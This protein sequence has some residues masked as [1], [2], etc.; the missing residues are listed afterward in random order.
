M[1]A[2]SPGKFL[3]AGVAPLRIDFRA[4]GEDVSQ[5]AAVFR[6]QRFEESNAQCVNIASGVGLAVAVL[7]RRSVSFRAKEPCV[8]LAVLLHRAGGVK[9]NQPD[10][11]R[12]VY[13]LYD[14][15]FRFNI[16]VNYTGFM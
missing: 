13:F 4:S 1:T 5:P 11:E 6:L 2:D 16:P 8:R 10:K 3:S 7:F 9:I 15:I 14:K 12:A